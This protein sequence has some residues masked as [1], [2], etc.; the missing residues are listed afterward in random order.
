MIRKRRKLPSSSISDYLEKPDIFYQHRICRSHFAI[1]KPIKKL[2]QLLLGIFS[3][4]TPSFS[5]FILLRGLPASG[6]LAGH[7]GASPAY[8]KMQLR[9]PR[10]ALRGGGTYHNR[11]YGGLN[12]RHS[13]NKLKEI[14][15]ISIENKNDKSKKMRY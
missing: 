4:R 7:G 10:G 9:P 6:P 1:A 14:I 11:G 5:I 12:P 2:S 3:Q 8:G 13:F 15:N